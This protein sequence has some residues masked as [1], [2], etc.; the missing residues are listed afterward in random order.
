[1]TDKVMLSHKKI[2]KEIEPELEF[3]ISLI[4]LNIS[5]R[6]IIDRF[7]IIISLISITIFIILLL[8]YLTAN[9]ESKLTDNVVVCIAS[10]FAI[11]IINIK[12]V[13]LFFQRN[14]F[15]KLTQ[16]S[17]S[18][19]EPNAE[20]E[21]FNTILKDNLT[22][23]RRMWLILHKITK[24]SFMLSG[25]FMAFGTVLK[26]GNDG[27]IKIPFLS[28]D[29]IYYKVVVFIIQLYLTVNV[30]LV[31]VY[32]DMI[33]I[34]F[35]F[36]IT[37]VLYTLYDYIS[38]NK[39]KMIE[40]SDFLKI[41]IL[42]HFDF[43]DKIKLINKTLLYITLLH[44]IYS[45]LIALFFFLYIRMNTQSF[46]GYLMITCVLIQLFYPCVVGDMINIKTKKLSEIFYQ[47]NW[48]DLSLKDQK[49]FL[50][51][52]G[53]IQKEYGFKAAE[54]FDINLYAFFQIVKCALSYCTILYTVSNH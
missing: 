32:I 33:I 34:F 14:N 46:V 37:A 15:R 39:D 24:I 2:Y 53:I 27:M 6:S 11:S 20:D 42:K 54:I 29:W 28:E 17:K 38:A 4:T 30:A 9:F 48:Y 5:N 3:G 41:I 51:V 26:T 45:L 40:N 52:L 12:I 8:L 18:L 35:G 22:R 36:E 44:F 50:I 7:V 47:T 13:P 31:T 49:T 43:I 25:C 21:M 10:F 23:F 19:N 16:W 1:M